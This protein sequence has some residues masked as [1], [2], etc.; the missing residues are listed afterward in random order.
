[1]N[2]LPQ[3]IERQINRYL[4]VKFEGLTFYPVTVEEYEV[5]M[6][7]AP[8]LGFMQQSLPVAMLSIPLLTAFLHMEDAWAQAKHDEDNGD[9]N[10]KIAGAL[11]SASV[12]ALLLALRLGYGEQMNERMSRARLVFEDR[13]GPKLKALVLRGNAGEAIEITPAK[14]GRIRP[15]IAAQNG[16]EIQPIDANPELVEADRSVRMANAPDLE[17]NLTDK[18]SFVCNATGKDESEVY[19][20]P[21]LKFNRRAASVERTLNFLVFGIGENSGMVKFKN[22]NPCPSPIFQRKHGSLGMIALDKFRRGAEQDIEN[23]S[24]SIDKE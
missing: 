13:N 14:F 1:M 22:G 24:K 15:L 3:E 8:A 20:W 17:V 11:F 16:I 5:F 23:V 18:I 4:P 10:A 6:A 7:C 21:I 12:L 2:G 19:N 9:P